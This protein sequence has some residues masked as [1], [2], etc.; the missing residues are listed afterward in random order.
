MKDLFR[1]TVYTVR[2]PIANCIYPTK[3][4]RMVEGKCSLNFKRSFEKAKAVNHRGNIEGLFKRNNIKRFSEGG[5]GMCLM[6]GYNNNSQS[7]QLPLFTVDSSNELN[8]NHF[9][10]C[11]L[12]FVVVGRINF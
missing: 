6:S 11:K 10:N 3:G 5:A 8:F 9:D 1:C 2:K 4:I 7:R 12:R